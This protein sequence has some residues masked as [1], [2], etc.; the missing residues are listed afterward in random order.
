VPV[1]RRRVAI[2]FV[3]VGRSRS[4]WGGRR[5]GWVVAFVRG[6][7]EGFRCVVPGCCCGC[8]VGVAGS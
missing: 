8:R 3:V 1:P 4:M 6:A 2:R 5:C 7:L